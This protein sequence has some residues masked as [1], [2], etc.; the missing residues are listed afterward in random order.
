VDYIYRNKSGIEVFFNEGEIV[1]EVHEVKVG[2]RVCVQVERKTGTLNQ[3]VDWCDLH[4][5]EGTKL[6]LMLSGLRG[7]RTQE[8][9]AKLA[10]VSRASYSHYETGRVQPTLKTLKRLAEIYGVTTDYLLQGE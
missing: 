1:R 3:I 6:S 8:D 7:R 10:G 9:V 4:P 2:D 5:I